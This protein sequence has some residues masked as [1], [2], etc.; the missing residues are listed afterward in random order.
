MAI[1]RKAG[2]IQEMT[3]GF[4]KRLTEMFEAK[5]QEILQV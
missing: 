4:V 1:A 2:E 3:D 5:E